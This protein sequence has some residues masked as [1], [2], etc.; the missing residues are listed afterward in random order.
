MSQLNPNHTNQC[1][2]PI[3][4][5][6]CSTPLIQNGAATHCDTCDLSWTVQSGIYNFLL[7]GKPDAV[8]LSA[9]PDEINRLAQQEGWKAAAEA[10]AS[11]SSN[12]IHQFEF[13]TSEARAD[14]RFLLPTTK[15]DIVLDICSGWGNMTAAFARTS[16]H[17]F[18]IDPCWD[19]LEFSKI[20]TA[21]E[22]LD[23]ITF[24]HSRPDEIPLPS[25]SCQLAL[26][27]DPLTCDFRRKDTSPSQDIH[28]PLLQSIWEVLV[29][30]GCLYLGVENRFS[31]KYLL[32]GRVPPSNLRFISLFPYSIA[33]RYSR[34][35]CNADYQDI[36]YTLR[37][38]K[39]VLHEF[40]FSKLETL[41]PIPLYP[42][43]RFLV[44]LKSTQ[45]ANFM[46]SRLRIHPGFNQTFYLFAKLAS[47]LGILQWFTPGFSIIAYKE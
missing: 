32:G 19:K 25:N 27:T 2:P 8:Q 41:F 30:G 31:Y 33:N 39:N 15:N 22:G 9:Q 10:L 14:F 20:R 1:I 21:Q 35:I 29:P 42:K 46:R 34:L 4:C 37:G 40:G 45:A 6:K 17:V 28:S 44:D 11:Q 36:T 24:I 23:N 5:P 12:P 18:V 26:L 3:V 16:K 43:F 47:S 38:V 7:N 13:I